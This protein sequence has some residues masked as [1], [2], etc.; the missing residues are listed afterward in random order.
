MF[1][2][3]KRDKCHERMKYY[4]CIFDKNVGVFFT[5]KYFVSIGNIFIP[6][7]KITKDLHLKR[8]KNCKIKALIVCLFMCH[9]IFYQ[10]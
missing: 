10:M 1:R 9:Y 2:L 6:L 4:D 5:N 8:N 3:I 7:S